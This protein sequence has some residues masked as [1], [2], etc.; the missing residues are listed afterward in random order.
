[1]KTRRYLL[2]SFLFYYTFK[3]GS[4][5]DKCAKKSKNRTVRL[6]MFTFT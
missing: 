5:C 6:K 2:T 1:V 3:R 4:F